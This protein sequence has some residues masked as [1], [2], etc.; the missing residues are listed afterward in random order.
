MSSTDSIESATVTAT[1]AEISGERPAGAAPVLRVAQWATGN[2]GRRALREVIRHPSLE[3]VG[4]LTYNPDKAGVDAGALCGEASTGVL[5][6]TDRA[7]I[8][9]LGADCVLYMPSTPDL[10]DVCALLDAGTN[11]VTTCGEFAVDGYSLGRQERARVIEACERGGTSVYA[12]GSSPGF[13]TEAL[14]FALLSLQRNTESI[15]IWEFA[16]MSRRDSPEMIFELMGFGRPPR[17]FPS[18]R[19]TR[20]L[21]NFGPSLNLLAEAA[22]RPVE[23]WRAFGEVAL[24]RDD[25]T[26]VAGLVRA[27]T[28]AA[29][30]TTIIGTSTDADIVR[31]TACWYCATEIDP[32][33]DLGPT[34]WR[35]KVVG[36]APF[37]FD[38]AFPVPLEDLNQWTPAL[39][40]NRPVNAVPYVCAARPGI[41]SILDLPPIT[42]AGPLTH[43]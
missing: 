33:W 1:R 9:A 19:V 15:E 28:V 37:E 6:T 21:G 17:E 34:G 20:L 3:L 42:P 11:I 36:E 5:A 32:Q 35:V 24:A 18:Q 38:L 25:T 23:S 39:T 43:T 10:D 41:L 27:G 26:I 13:I 8:R 14:P 22:G 30:R 2:I 40:A 31:F 4:V 29:Q 7:A 12:T 16:N